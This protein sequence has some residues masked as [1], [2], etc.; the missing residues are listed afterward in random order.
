[1]RS[2]DQSLRRQGGKHPPLRSFTATTSAQPDSI[3]CST[4]CVHFV[5]G[6]NN[7]KA[8]SPKQIGVGYH[9][10]KGSEDK[11]NSPVATHGHIC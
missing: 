4:H 3:L 9:F 1:M 2:P 5:K 10:V 6:Y 11:K 8:F 7:N